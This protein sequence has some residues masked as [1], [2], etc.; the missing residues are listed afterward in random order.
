M[1]EHTTKS[2]D[3]ELSHLVS[4]IAEMGGFT[5]KQ[6]VASIDAL[7]H[8]DIN[9]GRRVISADENLDCRQR[10]I[11]TYAVS[12]IAKRQPVADDLREIIAIVR[13]ANDLERIGDLSKNIG[14][15]VIGINGEEIPRRAL[16]GVQH[17][18]QLVLI[19]LRDALDC[20]SMRNSAKALNVWDR[21]GDID[22][23]YTSLFREMLTYM[24]EDPR[25]VGYGVHLLFCA[26]NIERM[27]DHVTN[28]AE[29]AYY[30]IEGQMLLDPR[31]KADLT[32]TLPTVFKS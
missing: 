18:T 28:I 24:M 29:A 8:G 12:V 27:G 1:S 31:R 7:I 20:F 21:D 9:L 17:M 10:E 19:Q 25:A 4:M 16:R 6:I 15:R 26:K 11:E 32:S 13:I 14:K 2:F 5:E 30:M 22:A 23:M 3:V